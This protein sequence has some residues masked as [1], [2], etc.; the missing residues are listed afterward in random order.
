MAKQRARAKLLADAEANAEEPTDAYSSTLVSLGSFASFNGCPNAAVYTTANSLGTST[1]CN[2]GNLS[3]LT[4]K[5]PASLLANGPNNNLNNHLNNHLN[6]NLNNHQLSG[7]LAGQAVA[8]NGGEM[9]NLAQLTGGSGTAKLI[10]S[11][12]IKQP[13]R[14]NGTQ[15]DQLLLK[16]VFRTTSSASSPGTA[17]IN[18]QLIQLDGSQLGVTANGLATTKSTTSTFSNSTDLAGKQQEQTNSIRNAVSISGAPLNGVGTINAAGK[19]NSTVS[20]SLSGSLAF[21][22]GDKKSDEQQSINSNRTPPL[23]NTFFV[24]NLNGLNCT[25][26]SSA[27]SSSGTP[28]SFLILNT[29][30]LETNSSLPGGSLSS[31]NLQENAVRTNS[32]PTSH[33]NSILSI[34]MDQQFAKLLQSNGQLNHGKIAAGQQP[35]TILYST[36]A[37]NSTAGLSTTTSS[38]SNT[39]ST[40][41]CATVGSMNM[42][43]QMA[44]LSSFKN[45]QTIGKIP[46]MSSGQVGNGQSSS[47]NGSQNCNQNSQSGQMTVNNQGQSNLT[48]KKINSNHVNIRDLNVPKDGVQAKKTNKAQKACR[49]GDAP[50]AVTLDSSECRPVE[51][52]CEPASANQNSGQNGDAHLRCDSLDGAAFKTKK[53]NGEYKNEFKRNEQY[54]E[55]YNEQGNESH[56]ESNQNDHCPNGHPSNLTQ[57]QT[58]INEYQ[59]TCTPTGDEELLNQDQL[60]ID[61]LSTDNGYGSF[62]GRT[63]SSNMD[64]LSA[65]LD[66]DEHLES[67]TTLNDE[68]QLIASVS[69]LTRLEE[70]SKLESEFGNIVNCS[71]LDCSDVLFNL[72]AFDMLNEFNLDYDLNNNLNNNHCSSLTSNLIGNPSNSCASSSLTTDLASGMTA[73]M[74][75]NNYYTYGLNLDL[76][77][78]S[79]KMEDAPSCSPSTLCN[80]S[81][82][83]PSKF[84]DCDNQMSLSDSALIGS[85]NNTNQPANSASQP[86]NQLQ[87]NNRILSQ[88]L[89]SKSTFS[90]LNETKCESTTIKLIDYNPRWIYTSGGLHQEQPA[91]WMFVI[92][93]GLS[94]T[95]SYQVKFSE[96]ATVHG[97]LLASANTVYG[98]RC[99]LPIASQP[100]KIKLQI[101]ENGKL[102]IDD[103]EFEFRKQPEMNVLNSNSADNHIALEPHDSKANKESQNLYKANDKKST[104][105]S[106]YKLNERELKYCLLERLTD[107]ALATTGSVESVELNLNDFE[108]NAIK[109]LDRLSNWHGEKVHPK[110]AWGKRQ[111]ETDYRRRSED[112][113]SN[114]N[115]LTILHLASALGY[116]NLIF[117]LLEWKDVQVNSLLDEQVNLKALDSMANTPLMW[118]MAKGNE[119][120]SKLLISLCCEACSIANS[121]AQDVFE[122]AEE[123]GHG[124]LANLARRWLADCLRTNAS[125]RLDLNCLEVENNLKHLSNP[126]QRLEASLDDSAQHSDNSNIFDCSST[127]STTISNLNTLINYESK[128][129]SLDE[130]ICDNNNSLMNCDNLRTNSSKPNV[131]ETKERSDLQDELDSLSGEESDEDGCE[132]SEEESDFSK[133]FFI[134]FKACLNTPAN[135]VHQLGTNQTKHQ[136]SHL[137]RCQ[138]LRRLI[139][140][141]EFWLTK[142]FCGPLL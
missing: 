103:L 73:N 72:E 49:K 8:I 125:L 84:F 138:T 20:T 62:D 21:V 140:Q 70:A 107:F 104:G 58:Y 114:I 115:S 2:G 48:V 5:A 42:V 78:L 142:T 53:L 137:P 120:S 99:R 113:Q 90:L 32:N 1:N 43:N 112:A 34:S 40:L 95:G 39:L 129:F 136:I 45:V 87:N 19:L 108:N 29:S 35:F 132:E 44:T 26:V 88:L 9:T 10:Q 135:S 94:F 123:E 66:E 111:D 126:S 81:P 50:N 131:D 51:I 69:K 141:G 63:S 96:L 65:R 15:D 13:A 75:T 7:S 117:N 22:N 28:G 139:D 91:N 77:N 46:L 128:E 11:I 122:V 4:R 105:Q 16:K 85:S 97:L 102:L 79:A 106:P 56:L 41:N 33:G 18:M 92:V 130:L 54:N 36:A 68:G 118:S 52:K 3:T 67:E 47:Q 25:P 101:L 71:E 124:D 110:V 60:S 27:T 57:S 31:S 119:A 6:N 37:V 98:I 14:E 116:T 64:C 38:A 76:N 17:L 89:T 59:M 133:L 86:G 80:N 61:K 74:S 127:A 30:G 134:R 82:S 83:L 24:N 12:V 109:V 23:L 55:Q 93:E 100:A 121:R